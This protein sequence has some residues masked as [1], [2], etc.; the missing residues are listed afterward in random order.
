MYY[1][2]DLLR[3]AIV[4]R[5]LS[6]AQFAEQTKLGINT[7]TKMWNGETNIG[8][9]GLITACEFL[10]IPL[11]ELFAPTP[12]RHTKTQQENQHESIS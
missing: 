5:D 4:N 3:S 6:R 1:R 2:K 10:E 12:N 11:S 9:R 7:V 8:L